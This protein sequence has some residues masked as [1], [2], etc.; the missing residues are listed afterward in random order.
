MRKKHIAYGL[1]VVMTAGVLLAGCG[2]KDDPAPG[3]NKK[4]S[5][6]FTL[7]VSGT[8]EYDQVD[9]SMGAGNHDASQYGAPVWKVNGVTQN[10]ENVLLLDEGD[11]AGSTKTYVIETVKPFNFGH[12]SV[13]YSNTDGG[14]ITLS[15]KV[16]IDGKVKT[17]VENLRIVDG[18]SQTKNFSYTPE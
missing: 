3:D 9:F 12:L 13:G 17:N 11:F 4:I 2:K 7:S 6:K 18:E 16:E 15:Y 1:Y 14:P 10:N 8:D 5:M